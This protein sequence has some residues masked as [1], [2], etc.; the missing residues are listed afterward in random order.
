MTSVRAAAAADLM[1]RFARRT[2][3][4]S[5][6]IDHRDINEVMLATSL[7]PDGFLSPGKDSRGATGRAL[8]AHGLHPDAGS[9][10]DRRVAASA[11]A[12]FIGSG[13]V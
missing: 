10:R 7:L 6:V 2:G 9:A 5:G 11:D 13:D 1:E 8:N 3:V 12:I 4:A